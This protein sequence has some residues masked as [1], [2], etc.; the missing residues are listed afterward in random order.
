MQINQESDSSFFTPHPYIHTH[1]H[2]YKL[3][4]ILFGLRLIRLKYTLDIKVK[5]NWQECES[6][7]FLMLSQ[8]LS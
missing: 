8:L 7:E 6:T 5:A 3:T 2:D 1:K 4:F